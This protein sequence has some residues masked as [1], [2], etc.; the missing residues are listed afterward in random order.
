M[1]I[2]GEE[3]I[4]YVDK[5]SKTKLCEFRNPILTKSITQMDEKGNNFIFG[6]HS[7]SLYGLKIG[8]TKNLEYRNIGTVSFLIAQDNM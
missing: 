7:G 2:F 6:D 5:N 1:L 3:S 8:T 4:T